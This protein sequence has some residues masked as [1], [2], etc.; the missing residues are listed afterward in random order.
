MTTRLLGLLALLFA[1]AATSLVGCPLPEQDDDDTPADD[2]DATAADDDDATGDDDDSTEPP[3]PDVTLSGEVIAVDRDTGIALTTEQYEQ[4]AGFILLYVLLDPSDLEAPL[5]KITMAEPS[6]WS[7]TL[8]ANFGSV[9]V[10]AIADDGDRIIGTSDMLREHTM[11]PRLVGTADMQDLDVIFDMPGDGSGWGGPGWGGGGSGGGG[12]GGGGSGGGGD[13]GGGGS[14]GG[15]DGGGGSGGGGSGGGGSGGGGSGGGG[16]GGTNSTCTTIAGDAN[17]FGL[18]DGEIAVTSN[19]VALTEG[20]WNYQ[21]LPGPGEFSLCVANTRGATA[22]LGIHDTDG[23]WMFEPSDERGEADANPIAVGGADLAGVQIDIPGATGG[24]TGSSFPTPFSYIDITGSVTHATY[25]GGDILVFASIGGPSGIQYYTA[26]LAAPGPFS[27]RAP[28]NTNNVILWAVADENANGLYEFD[29]EPSAASPPFSTG[30]IA[31]SGFQLDLV[32]PLD[33]SI[34]GAISYTGA[35][36]PGDSL[37]MGLHDDPMGQGA[38]IATIEV[39]SPTFP[40]S[41]F[42]DELAAGPYYVTAFLDVG[43]DSGGAVSSSEPWAMYGP[44]TLSGGSHPTGI[45][46]PIVDP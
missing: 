17:L 35:V 27:L 36:D 15:G 26:T 38:P 46:F 8:P 16:S 20:P 21:I 33:N 11:N 25:A 1:L 10:L 22:L 2:D 44:V 5:A 7:I 39:L 23:N 34:S 30:A 3:L 6:P 4:T 13:G 12:D 37:M 45:S 29:V 18:P 41:Y 19:S 32:D 40:V 31:L 9:Y 43:S 28:P 42:F 14:G 24:A